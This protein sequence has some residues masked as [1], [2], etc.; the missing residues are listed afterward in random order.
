[1]IRDAE[2]HRAHPLLL[3]RTRATESLLAGFED[4]D[5]SFR[6]WLLAKRQ[7]LHERLMRAL[8]G[9]LADERTEARV[10][11]ELVEA[12]INLD[13]TH[14]DACRHLMRARAEGGDVAGALRVYKTLW[15][16][17]DD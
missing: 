9:G 16:L 7:T 17:L 8:E 15:D 14:E 2:S 12:I 10:R 6:V 11:I 1:M 13:P 5:P 4:L 3:N